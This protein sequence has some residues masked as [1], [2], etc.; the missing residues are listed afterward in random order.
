[1]LASQEQGSC[2][3][4]KNA[5]LI[6]E[7]PMSRQSP[8]TECAGPAEP[9]DEDLA[10]LDNKLSRHMP[11]ILSRHALAMLTVV[12]RSSRA[13]RVPVLLLNRTPPRPGTQP[14]D[15]PLLRSRSSADARRRPRSRPG[16]AGGL[17]PTLTADALWQLYGAGGESG[18]SKISPTRVST[19]QR[20]SP[21]P[22]GWEPEST[23]SLIG[24]PFC[25]Q[26]AGRG[27]SY[28]PAAGLG[29]TAAGVQI[30]RWSDPGRAGQAVWA[31]HPGA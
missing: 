24:R 20:E 7:F 8:T 4:C 29:C 11:P 19:V 15:G 27:C 25:I 9:S 18:H 12:N 17:P 5:R 26:G 13:N 16:S 10:A 3:D 30:R 21:D 31:E 22:Q 6:R 23:R 14:D 28:G 1:M 2:A